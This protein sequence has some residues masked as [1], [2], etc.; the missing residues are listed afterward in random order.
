MSTA[1]SAVAK[2]GVTSAAIMTVADV[3]AQLLQREGGNGKSQGL[4]LLRTIRFATV[5]LTCHGPYF[6]LGFGWVDRIFGPPIGPGGRVLW[7]VVAKKVRIAATH[8]NRQHN[9]VQGSLHQA[10]SGRLHLYS[11]QPL[12]WMLIE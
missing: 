4:D 2:A 9:W 3:L 12:W 8:A 5:G 11:S 10:L 1:A 7:R 6:M